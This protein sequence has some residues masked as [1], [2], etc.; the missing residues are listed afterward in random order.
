MLGLVTATYKYDV[1]GAVR[2]QSG[3]GNTEYRF[4]G[5]Q[6]D[7]TLGYTYLRARYYDPATGRF[8]SKDPFPGLVTDPGS[9][10]HY[11]YVQNNPANL[12]DP[13]GRCFC[14]ALIWAGVSLGPVIQ[15]GIFTA[16]TF[17]GV[18][19]GYELAE[20]YADHSV[21]NPDGS[22]GS[23]AHREKIQERIEELEEEGLEHVGGGSLPEQRIR[24]ENGEKS[25]RRPDISMRDPETG[26]PY[27]ENVGRQ[28]QSGEPEARERRALDDIEE[29]TGIRPVFTPYN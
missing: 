26:E 23:P 10:H 9:Q 20:W 2:S 7:A 22:R 8:L 28:T 4:T 21:P 29:A 5:Q 16:A 18:A 11:S 3:T 14:I 17:L 13:S 25:Y 27:Y 19:G 15:A 6:D 24:T 1:F 12:T